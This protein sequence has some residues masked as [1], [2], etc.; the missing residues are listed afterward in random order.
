LVLEE[1]ETLPEHDP[2]PPPQIFFVLGL[3]LLVPYT[4]N[5]GP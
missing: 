4:L 2:A 5:P 3:A 1:G